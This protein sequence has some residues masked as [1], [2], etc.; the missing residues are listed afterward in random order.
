MELTQTVNLTDQY[1]DLFSSHMRFI[2]LSF[3]HT[4]AKTGSY[5][6]VKKMNTQWEIYKNKNKRKNQLLTIHLLLSVLQPL[7]V[8]PFY[9]GQ[10]PFLERKTKKKKLY[11]SKYMAKL[12]NGDKFAWQ[13]TQAF[14]LYT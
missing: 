5:W 13:Q 6:I 10:S 4:L 2:T 7:L 14:G 12:L 3:P 1:Q 9:I 11:I 8:P